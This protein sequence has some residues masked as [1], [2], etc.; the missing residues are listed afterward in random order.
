MTIQSLLK[1][2]LAGGHDILEQTVADC[3]PETLHKNLPG[4]TITNIGSIYAHIV[5]S[6]DMIIQGMLQ[7]KPPVYQA[8]GWATR[9]NVAMPAA[10]MMS[11]EWGKSVRMELA[12]FREYAKA[13]Y[14]ATDAYI[15]TLSDAGLQRK[16]DTGF[17]GEQTVAF[18]L[19]NICSWHVAEHGGEI[20]ALKGVQG[21]KGLPF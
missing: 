15:G 16:V 5:F 11:V 18:I 10:P 13:V 9:T 17:V 21:L 4:A 19:A 3:A 7:Q 8:Q 20:A 12:S 6:E 2:L 1:Q 14:A